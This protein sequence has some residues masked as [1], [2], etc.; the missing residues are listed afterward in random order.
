MGSVLVVNA[1]LRVYWYNFSLKMLNIWLKVNLLI[2]CFLLQGDQQKN[3]KFSGR[4]DIISI[5]NPLPWPR[6]YLLLTPGMYPVC[7]IFI[8]LSRAGLHQLLQMLCIYS[9]LGE[10]ILFFCAP[11]LYLISVPVHLFL[12][13][14]K[15]SKICWATLMCWTRLT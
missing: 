7:Q 9:Y 2:R 12:K 3:V 13:K 6:F 1:L 15:K 11:L 4:R 14:K 10:R 5:R 8:P